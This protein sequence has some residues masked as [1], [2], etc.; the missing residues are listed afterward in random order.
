ML[1]T[2]EQVHTPVFLDT[3]ISKTPQADNPSQDEGALATE[4]IQL[5][6]VHRDFQTS[7]KHQT[8]EFRSLR[9]ELG[10]HLAEMKQVLARPGRNGRWSMFLK[11]H[12]I[13]RATADR[14]VQKYIGSIQPR[15]NC[16]NEQLA[17]PTE[18]E[19]QKVFFKAI[20]KLRPV[21]RTPQSV[22]R[23]VDLLTLSCGGTVRRVTEEGILVIKPSQNPMFGEFPVGGIEGEPQTGLTQPEVELDQELM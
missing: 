1:E 17:E 16:L 8:R 12:Q 7:I 11:E 13:P 20:R 5:W 3:P 23:F 22:Y 2:A 6:Q 4:I 10:K 15:T 14:L 19:I 21:L 9:T 18:E